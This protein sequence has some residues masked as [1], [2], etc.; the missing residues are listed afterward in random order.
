MCNLFLFIEL[1]FFVV[2]A[3]VKVKEKIEGRCDCN[4]MSFFSELKK[5]I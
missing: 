5:K 4:F 2:I 3:H 1:F